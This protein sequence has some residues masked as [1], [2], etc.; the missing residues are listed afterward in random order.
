M[1]TFFAA[2]W[3]TLNVPQNYFGG[4]NNKIISRSVLIIF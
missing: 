4:L 2:L 3:S 1:L